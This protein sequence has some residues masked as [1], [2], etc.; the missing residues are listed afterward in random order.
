M[1]SPR[2]REAAGDLKIAWSFRRNRCAIAQA[3]VTACGPARNGTRMGSRRFEAMTA[4]GTPV[5]ELR[6]IRIG[7]ARGCDTNG[8]RH[9][10]RRDGSSQPCG[11]ASAMSNMHA[12]LSAMVNSAVGDRRALTLIGNSIRAHA[13]RAVGGCVRSCPT[14]LPTRIR[15]S[16]SRSASTLSSRQLAL[17]CN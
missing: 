8:V 17:A 4:T 5:A 3:T 15:R 16:V 9:W 11:T 12:D 1:Q 14:R 10:D 6:A 7:A 2:S 13:T